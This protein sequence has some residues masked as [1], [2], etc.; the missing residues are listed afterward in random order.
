MRAYTK[1]CLVAGWLV[2]VFDCGLD[3]EAAPY[4]GPPALNDEKQPDAG[5]TNCDLQGTWDVTLSTED[6]CSPT[7]EGA[8]VSVRVDDIG[9]DSDD[10]DSAELPAT[11]TCG[12]YTHQVEVTADGCTI[13]SKSLANWCASGRPQCN[14]YELTLQVR[15]DGKADVKGDYRRCWCGSPSSFGTKVKV[16]GTAAR[17]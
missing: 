12:E 13:T 16:A 11:S 17:R 2:C 9:T 14:D 5:P 6:Q 15:E 8:A 7:E 3:T 4:S 1:T 10:F